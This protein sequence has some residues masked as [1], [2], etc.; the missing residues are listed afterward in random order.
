MATFAPHI[1]II[2]DSNW[3]QYAQDQVVDGEVKSRGLIP[4]DW[5]AKPQ[6]CFAFAPP[7]PSDR[8]IPESEW[9]GRFQEQK[10]KKATLADLRE[11][12]YSTLKSLNQNSY[13]YCWAFST[14]KT[15]M[16]LR[17]LMNLPPKILSG[18]AV[19]SIV[20]NY[21]N[22]GGWGGESIEFASKVGIPELSVWPQGA[23][24]PKYDTQEMRANAAL[25]K[26]T[27]WWDGAQNRETAKQQ[28]VTAFL[29]GKPCVIDLDWWSHSVCGIA[30]VSLSP[31]RIVIDNSWDETSGDRGLYILEGSK[32]VPDGLWI[33]RVTIAA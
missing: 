18:W 24:N 30:I 33:P 7:F 12:N 3:Q 31:F 6:G 5:K 17:A 16:Y 21:R 10:E 23:V 1:P 8:I 14:T 22:E 9:E 26:L 19:G 11:A 28:M 15:L 4:R 13:G 27:E 20:K 29:E 32:A 25:N 2:D